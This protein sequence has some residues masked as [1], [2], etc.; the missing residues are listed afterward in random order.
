MPKITNQYALAALACTGGI[1]FGFDISSMSLILGLNS[2]NSFFGNITE[3]GVTRVDANLQAGITASMPAGSA[4]GAIISGLFSD[5]FGRKGAIMAACCFWL[6]GSILC[7]ASQAVAMLIVGRIINGICVGIASAQVPVYLSELAQPKIRGRL[8]G[9][10]Q[11]AITWGICIF[12]YVSYGCS[13]IGGSA[14]LNTA[15]FRVPWALQ[16]IPALGLMALLPF[17]P[18]SPRY[19]ASKNRWDEALEVLADVHAKGNKE[20]A[21]V[22]A[23][24]KEIQ[25]NIE[26]E[27]S[28]SWAEL[29][30]GRYLNR[31]HIVVFTQIWAQLTGMNV[32]MYYISY[33]MEMAGYT[34]NI[35][36]ISSSIQYVINVLMTVPALIFLD[37]W[38]RRPTLMIGSILMATFL[39]INAA[40]LATKG[41]GLN[42]GFNGN[43][44]VRWIINEDAHSAGVALIA[45]TY[46]FV[47]SFAS[48]WGPVSWVYPPELFP[49]RL[50][51][52]SNSVSTLG[53]WLFNFALAYFVPPSFKNIQWKTYIVFAVFCTVMTVHVFLAFPETKNLSLEE[54]E[55]VFAAKLPAWKTRAATKN[56]RLASLADKIERGEDHGQ[57][58]KGNLGYTEAPLTAVD[59]PEL[60]DKKETA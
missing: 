55:E 30:S 39:Y 21:L 52:K 25:T 14:S 38:G 49:N 47:A 18:E 13:F 29:F 50:R 59:S 34:G 15:Q 54:V 41:H 53:N 20:N 2:W 27:N 44:A 3:N 19:L 22:L 36:L 10:Q 5:R 33:V 46:L 17:M 26:E 48:T 51:A 8:V 23:E 6:I 7:A 11:W 16:T 12:Y 9:F 37:K 31:T 45:M 1:L 4:L 60:E 32:M 35:G 58:T 43:D 57:A 42:S 28:S 56:N 40:I 24:F